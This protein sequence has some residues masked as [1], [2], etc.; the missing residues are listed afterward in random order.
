[1]KKKTIALLM[2]VV[3]LFGATVGGTIAW[4][5]AQSL[6]VTNTFTVG[7]INVKLDEA[8]LKEGT[9]DTYIKADGTETT[10]ITEARRVQGNSYQLIPGTTYPK[11]PKVTIKGSASNVDAYLFIKFEKGDADKYLTYNSALTA[12]FS[13]WQAVPDENNVWYVEVPASTTD[14]SQE[15]LIGNTVT[16]KDTIV[17]AQSTTSDA[18]KMPKDSQILKWTAYAVQKDNL[19]VTEAW[20]VALTGNKNI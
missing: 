11:D 4:L 10:D 1:M 20:K 15:L 13:K 3:M 19:T 2:A 8:D 5:Y 16:V 6:D 14:F 18:L 12:P 9:T 7:D 17:D